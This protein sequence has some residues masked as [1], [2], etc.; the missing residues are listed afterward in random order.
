[1][2]REKIDLYTVRLVSAF[3]KD[4]I[5]IMSEENP[6]ALSVLY[7]LLENPM[8]ITDI[9]HLDDM[10]IRG[11]QIWVGYKD[12]CYEDIEKFRD[13]IRGRNKDMV[14]TINQKCQKE[15]GEIAV[16]SGASYNR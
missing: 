3:V 15:Q 5:F 1:M 7:K 2:V 12:H 10:N 6:G 4:L 9:L 13:S 8:G 14:E 16:T 11:S